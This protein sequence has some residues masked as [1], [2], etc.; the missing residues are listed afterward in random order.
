MSYLINSQDEWRRREA[1]QRKNRE[2]ETTRAEIGIKSRYIDQEG[3]RLPPAIIN[4]CEMNLKAVQ[5]HA[6]DKKRADA[7]PDNRFELLWNLQI[8][9]S[10]RQHRARDAY[11]KGSKAPRPKRRSNPAPRPQARY[12]RKLRT[13][14]M[15]DTQLKFGERIALD[16]IFTVLGDRVE[17]HISHGGL[18]A[19]IGVE[20]RTIRNYMCGLDEE[21][22]IER[23]LM[24][25][26]R[27]M[28]IGSW[29]TLTAKAKMLLKTN[30]KE[31]AKAAKKAAKQGFPVRT[32]STSIKRSI[33]K[34][35]ELERASGPNNEVGHS[36]PRLCEGG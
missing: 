13:E 34:S 33:D 12:R 24:T 31:E 1:E 14:H 20:K 35:I 36:P 3:N 6:E 7:I 16:T 4:Q 9:L 32:L 23:H 26:R 29:I 28:I 22:W 21:G 15:R 11:L 18:A 30:V 17:G 27:G 19:D 2:L 5:K 10:E 25:D 8:K